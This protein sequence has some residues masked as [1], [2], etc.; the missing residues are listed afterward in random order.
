MC[1]LKMGETTQTALFKHQCTQCLPLASITGHYSHT[2]PSVTH[3][4]YTH[5]TQLTLKTTRVP[6]AWFRHT[7]Q[8]VYQHTQLSS[9]EEVVQTHPSAKTARW[10]HMITGINTQRDLYVREPAQQTKRAASCLPTITGKQLSIRC[11]SAL[12]HVADYP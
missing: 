3:P 2:P 10:E 5:R 11:T 8:S 7:T 6:T 9:A 4:H 1:R 12:V